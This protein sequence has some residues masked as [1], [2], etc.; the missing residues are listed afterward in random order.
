M[1][2]WKGSCR[3]TSSTDAMARMTISHTEATNKPKINGNPKGLSV[4][5]NKTPSTYQAQNSAYLHK[6][7][8]APDKVRQSKVG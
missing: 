5:G 7:V 2:S 6:S 8:A 3:Q 4:G 1:A